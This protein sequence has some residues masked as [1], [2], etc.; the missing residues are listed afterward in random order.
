MN[1]WINNTRSE[2]LETFKV[3]DGVVMNDGEARLLTGTDNLILAGRKILEFGPTFAVIKKGEHGAM[4]FSADETFVLPAFTTP[5]VKDPTGAGDS[6]AAGMMAYLAANDR[7][8]VTAL[9][10]ALAVGICTASITIEDFSLNSL[11][12]ADRN[13]VEK[14]LNKLRAMLAFE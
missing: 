3:V 14:R 8:D 2:L 10:S 1:L 9:K 12:S 4:L 6:F 7:T 5:L 13:V 11:R